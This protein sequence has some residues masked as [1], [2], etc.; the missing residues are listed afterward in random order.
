MEKCSRNADSR[1]LFMPKPISEKIFEI[2]G[3]DLKRGFGDGNRF[4]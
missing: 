1:Y 2:A 4:D 3:K